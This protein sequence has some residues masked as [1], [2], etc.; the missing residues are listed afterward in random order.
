MEK[1][2]YKVEKDDD[3]KRLDVYI[4]EKIPIEISRNLVQNAI[5]KGQITVNG[6]QKKPHYKVKQGDEIQIDFHELVE[7][8][9][10]EEILP[11]NIP[12]N[13]LYEDA[14]LIVI[15]KPAGLIVHPTPNIK[16]G[17]LV[18]ALMY[19]VRDLDRTMQDSNRLGIVHRLDKETSGVM[20]VAKTSFSY[21][22]LSKEFKER[23]TTKYYLAV[24]EGT[25]KEKEGEINLPL[26]RHPVLRHKRAVVYD[27]REAVTE[28][29]A[30]KEFENHATLVWIRLKTG[31]THQI[32]VHFKYLGNP[33]IGDSLYGKNKIDKNLQISVNRQMLHAL[34]LGFYH[35]KTKEWME[36]L[37]P[38]PEDFKNLLITLTNL[39]GQNS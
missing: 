15:N 17:T 24:I 1:R 26:G 2:I 22:L 39:D 37:A 30:L 35:P 3:Q 7:E 36:F 25:L 33:I 16:S 34:K 38:L 32:R 13:I 23:M 9:K 28:Y 18:N 11:E 12:L 5:T 21:H 31:R 8:T 10:E 20:V 27:G 6:T 14:E 4:V 29:K 19:H